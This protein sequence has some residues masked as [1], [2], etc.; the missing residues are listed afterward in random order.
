MIDKKTLIGYLPEDVKEPLKRYL[1]EIL[2]GYYGFCCLINRL[3]FFNSLLKTKTS[4]HIGCG[5]IRIKNCLNLDYRATRATDLVCD[6][7]N[8]SLFKDKTFASVY[9]HA[10]FEHLYREQRIPLLLEVKRV[11]IDKGFVLFLGMPDFERAAIAYLSKE[12][13]LFSNVFD[14]YEVYRYTHGDPE[15]YPSWWLQQLHKSLF[16]STELSKLLT[17]AGF[18]H[19]IIFRYCFRSE[20]L[21]VSLGFYATISEEKK[22]SSKD[23]HLIIDRFTDSVNKKTITI[24]KTK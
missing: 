16:D 20:H 7:S 6:C 9:S 11:L 14:I 21:P 2:N 10:F 22:L 17:R 12:K 3:V 5:D 13:G 4:L 18:K 19:F 8:L 24:L 23:L 15:R 1:M